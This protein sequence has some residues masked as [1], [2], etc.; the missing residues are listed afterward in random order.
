MIGQLLTGRYLILEK[1][2]AGGFS[3]T[4]LA[5]DKYL[6]RHPLCVV[7]RL[8]LSSNH[9]ISPETAQRLFEMEASVLERLGQHHTQIPTLFAYCHEQE[10]VYLVQEY[11]EG[12]NLGR[13]FAQGQRLSS[14]T[15][16]KLLRELLPVLDFLHSRRVI[17]KD[18]KPSNL[19]RRKRDG[20]VVLIDFGAACILPEY[21]S[22]SPA[23]SEDLSLVI[24]TPGYM[25]DEQQQGMPQLNS[26]LYA[27]GMLVIHLLTGVHPREFK[28]DLISGEMDWHRYLGE[29]TVEPKLIAILDRMVRVKPGDRYLLASD[30]LKDLRTLSRVRHA[31]Q[32]ASDSKW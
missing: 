8:R 10:Q 24:G 20:K 5:R 30:V 4:Y 23:E 21:P 12:E 26:D 25:S 13:W 19:I 6:P 16:T 15:A 14:K 18:I 31:W 9:S 7:K 22:H 2:G 3:E 28:Q 1:L 29:Q 32:Q 27:L 11:V 17:H